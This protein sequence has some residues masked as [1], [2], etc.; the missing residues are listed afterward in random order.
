M[1]KGDVVKA[2][3]DA[4]PWESFEIHD[5]ALVPI[6]D[7]AAGLVYE[8]TG[9]RVSDG[10]VYRA[11]ILSVYGRTTGMAADPAP[12]DSSTPD[13]TRS[14]QPVAH[15][16][17]TFYGPAASHARLGDFGTFDSSRNPYPTLTDVEEQRP[18]DIL[19]RSPGSRAK[20]QGA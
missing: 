10:Y 14:A 2:M 6:R 11:N 4:D 19:P 7:D 9:R 20:L 13:K 16:E 12:A 3:A 5:P 17:L 8:A 18:P 15:R 1:D